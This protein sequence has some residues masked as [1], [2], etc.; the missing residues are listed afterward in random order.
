MKT[1]SCIKIADNLTDNQH[2]EIAKQLAIHKIDGIEIS[3]AGR[4]WGATWETNKDYDL[5]FLKLCK[6]IKAIRI[7][8]PGVTEIKPILHLADSLENLQL[9][10]L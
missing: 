3:E 8:L 2:R 5:S 6:G 4:R 7:Y 9:G 10:E 1:I